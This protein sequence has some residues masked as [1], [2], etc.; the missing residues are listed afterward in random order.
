[1][2]RFLVLAAGIRPAFPI[3]FPMNFLNSLGPI[4][5]PSTTS[6][7]RHPSA[8]QAARFGRKP[9]RVCT[10]KPA[11]RSSRTH[12]VVFLPLRHPRGRRYFAVAT[13]C[14][15][16]CPLYFIPTRRRSRTACAEIDANSSVRMMWCGTARNGPL[17]LAPRDFAIQRRPAGFPQW[18]QTR[19]RFCF[20]LSTP[21]D[22]SISC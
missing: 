7:D 21:R 12:F 9:M 16:L 20:D 2:T 22:R 13:S 5:M 8:Y 6:S 14:P 19:W 18:G 10:S 11:S 4:S 1:M 3:G 17:I 15:L